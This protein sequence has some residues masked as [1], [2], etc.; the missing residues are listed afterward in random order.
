MQLR[1]AYK[2]ELFCNQVAID[3]ATDL[4]K[5]NLHCFMLYLRAMHSSVSGV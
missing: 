5:I 3:S 2:A 4:L 1:K